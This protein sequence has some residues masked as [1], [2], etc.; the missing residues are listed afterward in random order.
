MKRITVGDVVVATTT[1]KEGSIVHARRGN[2]G[3]VVALD[4][5][6]IPTVRFLRSGT[7][8]IVD[9]GEVVACS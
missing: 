1:V 8:T 9:D 3:Q 4:D 5:A 6:G 2:V 7:A